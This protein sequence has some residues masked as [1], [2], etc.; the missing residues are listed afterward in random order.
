M[1]PPEIRKRVGFVPQDMQDFH[2]MTV[3]ECL[4]F[5]GGFYELWDDRLVTDLQRQ[6]GLPE[7]RI[8]SLSPGLRQRV[9]VLLAVGHRPALLVLD[10]PTASLD[11]GARRDFLRLL[12]DLNADT[13]QTVLLSSQICSDIER[14]CSQVAILH[15]GRI[16]VHDAVDDLKEQVRCVVGCPEHVVGTDVLARTENRVWLRNWHAYDLSRATRVDR[17]E[18]EELFLDVTD[19]VGVASGGDGCGV[20]LSAVARP[21]LGHCCVGRVSGLGGDRSHRPLGNHGLCPPALRGCDA[22]SL[23]GG[24]HRPCP[25]MA[26]C[27]SG[28]WLREGGEL[29]H[30]GCRGCGTRM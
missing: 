16:V 11:P 2:W 10:E 20:L 29:G 19:E 8:G 15:H 12:G 27:G 28:A 17:L 23:A 30:R 18:L 6:W 7:E 13:Q 1:P 14:I 24:L 4:R 3:S 25:Q 26:Q 9:A 5:V 22:R 21:S